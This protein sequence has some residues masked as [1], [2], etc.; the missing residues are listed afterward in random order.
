MAISQHILTALCL[1]ASLAPSLR[2]A[3]TDET[4]DNA[5]KILRAYCRQCHAGPADQLKSGLRILDLDALLRR[6]I[7]RKG[8]PAESELFQLV[9]CGS[10]PP[11]NL[12][13]PAPAEV[14]ALR[15]W[16]SAGAHDFPPEHGEIYVRNKI[17]Q[18]LISLASLHKNDPSDQSDPL[19]YQRYVSFN[20]LLTDDAE[21]DSTLWQDALVKALNHLSWEPKPVRV[22]PIDPPLD[23]IFRFDERDLGWNLK[24]FEQTDGG[25]PKAEPK[26]S[27]VDLYDLVLLEYP[28]ATSPSRFDGNPT[29]AEYVRKAGLVQPVLYLRGDWLVSTATQPPLYADMLRLPRV[30][31]GPDGLEARIQAAGPPARATFLPSKMNNGPQLVERRDAAGLGAYWRTFDP[32]AADDLKTLLLAADADRG[33]LMSF[34]LPN[35]LNGY[36]IA[37][38]VPAKDGK[39][40]VRLTSSAPTAWV[41]D[42]NAPDRIARN[43]LSC[44]RCHDSGVEAFADAALSVLDALPADKKNA[45]RKLFPGKETMDKL[46]AGDVARCQNATTAIF[47]RPLDREPLTPL[48]TRFLQGATAAPIPPTIQTAAG[49]ATIP[50]AVGDAHRRD[51]PGS[52]APDLDAPPLPPLDGLTMPRYEPPLPPPPAHVTFTALNRTTGKHYTDDQQPTAFAPGD[53]F[54]IEVKNEGGQDVYIEL[55]AALMNG[56]MFIHQPPKK[57]AAGAVYHYPEDRP[58]IGD[59]APRKSFPMELPPGV[60]RYIL[61]ASDAPFPAGVRLHSVKDKGI[62]DRVVHLPDKVHGLDFD[63]ARLVKKTLFVETR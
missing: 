15:T 34:P 40:L 30:L 53:E 9:D 8:K 20:H 59:A 46:L 31:T 55:V 7:V 63:P 57:L 10:M 36:Y 13:K 61:F 41:A 2:A 18:D 22:A 47:G 52:P 45:L 3:D 54:A 38:S 1:A 5:R 33:G 27:A 35:G 16:I 11:G 14:D 58:K 23:T 50:V 44:I 42:K 24:P 39:R 48:T 37:E 26:S 62:A 4:A 43:G 49:D 25:D 17:E 29:L 21:P 56:H 12:P 6:K 32:G 51:A 60:D 19:P 28:F